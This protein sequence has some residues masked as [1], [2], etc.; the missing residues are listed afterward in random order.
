MAVTMWGI[1]PAA[2][3]GSRVQ[4][5]GFSKELLPVGSTTNSEPHTLRPVL[6]HIIER[7]VVGGAAKLCLVVSP[8]KPDITKYLARK[9]LPIDTCYVFQPEP[10]GLVDAI[11]RPLPFLSENVVVMIG[12]PDTLWFP[13]NGYLELSDDV[14][15]L[16]MFPVKQPELFDVVLLDHEDRVTEVQVKVPH[17]DSSWI[18][19]AIK[20]PGTVYHALHRLWV[21]RGQVDVQIGTLLNAYIAEGGIVKGVRRGESYVDVG[22]ASGYADALRTLGDRILT[23]V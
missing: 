6:D 2:G 22:T 4:P 13:E 20:L 9:S 19:G 7:L 12:L 1:V 15:S 8:E 3:N 21:E 5:L 18:W 10:I 23:T 16:L 11:F 14:P 17:P